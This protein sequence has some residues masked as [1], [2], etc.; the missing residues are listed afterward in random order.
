MALLGITL[1]VATAGIWYYKRKQKRTTMFLSI[2]SINFIIVQ[3]VSSAAEYTQKYTH[4]VW[5]K[6]DSGITVGI[7]YD[8]GYHTRAEIEKDWTML[9]V[10]QRKLLSAC[11]GLKGANAEKYLKENKSVQSLSIPFETAKQVFIRSTLPKAASEALAIYPGLNELLPDAAGAII[12]MVLNRGNSL[13][14][15]RRIEMRQIVPLIQQKDYHGIA[16]LID[17]SKRLWIGIGMDGLVK[18]REMEAA[19]VKSSLRQYAANEIISISNHT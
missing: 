17:H 19:L 18:R 9:P 14:G 10:Q 11:A 8:L 1:A 13:K 2:K 7:G 3:E 16:Q 4:P 6:G 12:S 5:P 15:E